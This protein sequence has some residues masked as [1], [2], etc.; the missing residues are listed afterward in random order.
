[1]AKL[2]VRRSLPTMGHPYEG[3]IQILEIVARDQ[4]TIQEL[5]D[6]FQ[7]RKESGR[8]TPFFR[9]G[10]DDILYFVQTLLGLVNLDGIRLQLTELGRQLYGQL[11]TDSFGLTL[12]RLILAVSRQ[13][14]TYFA[15]VV[16]NLQAQVSLY[17][18]TFP[19]SAYQAILRETNKRS[20][21]E[22]R[23]LLA[24]CGV[25]HEFSSGIEINAQALGQ[26]ADTVDINNMVDMIRSIVHERGPVA[27]S[28][29]INELTNK[30][31]FQ[32]VNQLETRLRARLRINA[33]RTTEY[34]DGVLE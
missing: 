21:K 19:A 6:W 14:F 16:D 17:G 9:S 13:K 8:P 26:D 27:Y 33:T 34:I 32:R 18:R 4:P 31:S 10:D 3:I 25:V 20:A 2:S 15:Q 11:H 1:M 28:D 12:F 22:I 7:Q 23:S 24:G 5:H 30:Y 29:A